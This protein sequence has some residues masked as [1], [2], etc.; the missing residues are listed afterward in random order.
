[1]GRPARRSARQLARPAKRSLTIAG[2]RT[3][4][5]LE[6]AFWLVL[7][8]MA[9][10]E[11]LSLNALAA[12]VDGERLQA[13]ERESIVAGQGSAGLSGALRVAA[14]LWLVDRSGAGANGEAGDAASRQ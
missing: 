4:V 5:S 6:E 1:M 8:A 10:D 2:H 13:G 9:E 7:R 3:S 12:R 14:L 11:G